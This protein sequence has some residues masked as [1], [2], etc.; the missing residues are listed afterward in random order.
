MKLKK[1]KESPA[2]A[3]S[4]EPSEQGSTATVE[5]PVKSERKPFLLPK[6]PSVKEELVK[7]EFLQ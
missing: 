5:T 3:V 2:K 6:L 7:V 1:Q 4:P